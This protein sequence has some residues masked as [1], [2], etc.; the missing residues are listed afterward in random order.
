VG[1]SLIPSSPVL[2]LLGVEF[3]RNFTTT[4]SLKKLAT[5][6]N[7]RA[8]M[9][10]RLSFSMPPHLLTNFANGLLMGKIMAFSPVNIP[11]RLNMEDR[12]QNYI[13]VTEDINKAI[14]AT[15]RTITKTKLSDK[16]CSEVV[17]RKSGL[18]CLNE[19]VAST[20]AVTVWKA[21][22]AMDPLGQRI[23]RDKSSLQC[24]RSTTSK[25][26]DLLVQ[27]YPTLSTNIMARIWNTVPG[28]QH[29][30]TLGTAKS[31]AK[32][33]AKDIPR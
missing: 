25:D 5:A 10:Y 14:K 27:G 26:I 29:A 15:A 18:K 33:W 16:V 21:K 22:K 17:L 2:K 7:T 4:P 31:L 8:S 24:T 30:T 11:T 6:A 12:Y 28:L 1:S 13:G 20:T 9:M 19:A 3:D 23:F 32:K